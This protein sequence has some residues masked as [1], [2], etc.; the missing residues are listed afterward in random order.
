MLPSAMGERFQVLGLAKDIVGPF[1]GFSARDL[2]HR[3]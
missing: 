1:R 3:L 2:S